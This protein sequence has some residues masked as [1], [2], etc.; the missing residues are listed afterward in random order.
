M[1]GHVC[2][3]PSTLIR[4]ANASLRG[5]Y[6]HAASLALP[7]VIQLPLY[8]RI[9]CGRHRSV[10]ASVGEA[11]P[12]SPPRHCQHQQHSWAGDLRNNQAPL[13]LQPA[14]VK[15][16]IFMPRDVIASSTAATFVSKSLV[17]CRY[18]LLL[19]LTPGSVSVVSGAVNRWVEGDLALRALAASLTVAAAAFT[20][21]VCGAASLARIHRAQC[22]I[23]SLHTAY[24][25]PRR[26]FYAL[27]V[28][29]SPSACSWF[30]RARSSLVSRMLSP[31]LRHSWRHRQVNGDPTSRAV[32]GS[33]HPG[34]EFPPS[35]SER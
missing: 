8:V 32:N 4:N 1:N 3:R 18:S 29:A 19:S 9:H 22:V 16:C 34:V 28:T 35:C 11:R 7:S 24:S 23:V 31:G 27:T 6:A 2:R 13:P 5:D 17:R 15:L 33:R 14:T 12:E 10:T 21:C 20:R 26:L 25:L 30:Y